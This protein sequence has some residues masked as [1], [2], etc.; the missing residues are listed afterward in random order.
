MTKSTSCFVLGMVSFLRRRPLDKERV[1]DASCVARPSSHSG[2][3]PLLPTIGNRSGAERGG[4][5]ARSQ[6]G[7]TGEIT[8][9]IVVAGKRSPVE[10]SYVGI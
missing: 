5:L 1:W 7:G 3:V 4:S 8:F 9:E 2:T 10:V 6:P